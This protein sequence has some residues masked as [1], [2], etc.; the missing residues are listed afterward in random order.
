VGERK[1]ERERKRGRER[2]RLVYRNGERASEGER[3][4]HVAAA[5]MAASTATVAASTVAVDV[6][7]AAAAD[8]FAAHVYP[9]DFHSFARCEISMTPPE[10]PPLLLQRERERKINR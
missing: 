6:V 9:L 5:T 8:V 10:T 3:D 7:V 2:E 4:E 1:K